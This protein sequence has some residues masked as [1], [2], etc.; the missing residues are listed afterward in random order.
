M[1]ISKIICRVQK[2]V[3]VAGDQKTGWWPVAN[4]TSDNTSS[5]RRELFDIDIYFDG[6]GYLLCYSTTN[7]GLYGDS[8]HL[9]EFDAKQ[10]AL[11][12]FGVQIN[13]WS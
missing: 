9:T 13:E 10:T 7:Q 1:S 5:T 2:L 4:T 8:W 6:S 11:E 3:F 12:E